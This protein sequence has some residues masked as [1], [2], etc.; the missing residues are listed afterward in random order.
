MGAIPEEVDDRVAPPP[1]PP[2]IR[3]V[4]E[5][6]I[7]IEMEADAADEQV[8]GGSASIGP[9]SGFENA[10]GDEITQL[11]A[12]PIPSS[13]RATSSDDR[14]NTVI[15]DTNDQDDER[16]AISRAKTIIKGD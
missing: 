12:E 5:G 3:A 1:P 15:D 6:S 14:M 8:D 11:E 9:A 13:R 16:T 2:P 4:S 10:S 7:V